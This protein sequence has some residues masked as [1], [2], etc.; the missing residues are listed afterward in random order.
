MGRTKTGRWRAI[1]LIMVNVLM[2]AHLIQWLIAGTTIAPI[3]PSEA[4]E[5]L[6]VGMINAGAIL[7]ALTFLSTLI[8]GRFFC[9]WLC[10]M[11]A[12]QDLC[13][14]M[15]N[16][17][18]IR[19]KPFRSRLLILFPFA[20]GMY[21]F[22]WPTFKRLALA[23]ILKSASIDWPAWL[24]P[25]EPISKYSTELI[26]DDFWATMPPWFIAVPFLFICGFAAVYFLGAKGFCTYGCPY[27]AFFKPMDKVAPLR[28]R[29]DD[30]CEQCGYCTSVCTSNV[31][32]SEEVRDFGMVV[33]AGCMKTLDCI[34]A[35]PNDALSLGFGKPALGAKPRSPETYIE[36]KAKRARR[37]DLSIGQ[38]VFASVL[39]L[40]F[41]F[42]TR[43]L[44]DAVPMLLAGGLAAIGVMIVMT[45]IK[46]FGEQNA[47][48][49][50]RQLKLQGKLKPAGFVMIL[51]AIVFVFASVWSGHAKA[52]RWRGDV[53]YA[54]SSLPT[55]VLMRTEFE[56]SPAQRKQAES[57][58]WAYQR[59]DSFNNGGYGWKLSA[60]HRLRLSY[61]LGVLGHHQQAYDQLVQ[62]IEDGSPTDQLV[63]QAGQLLIIAINANPPEQEP[64]GGFESYKRTKLLDLYARSLEMHPELHAIRAELARSAFSVGEHEKAQAYWETTEFDDDP[65]F[66]L[67]QAGYTSFTG[68]MGQTRVLYDRAIE[69]AMELDEPEA[70]LIDIARAAMQNRM[71]DLALE[72]AQ[73]AVDFEDATT[74]T[75]LAAGEIA[76][77]VGQSELGKERALHA[78]TMP[79]VD[80]PMVQIRAAN[81][82]ALPG[83]TDRTRE[84]L[85][86][87]A[88]RADDP[89]E[90]A[91]IARGMV[92]AGRSLG[93]Q[94]MLDQGLEFFKG[95]TRSYPDLY[96][97][98][99]DYALLLYQ[100]G[101]QQEAADELVRVAELD[102]NNA[103]FAKRAG[104]ILRV[105]GDEE[106]AAKWTEEAQKRALL[107]QE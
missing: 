105:V 43:G 52:M 67:A 28:V 92:F 79:G 13:A 72:L 47:R 86:D 65:A 103:L 35:C 101:H 74:L 62:V 42:A 4:M 50:S 104:E 39:F 84:L 64:E 40:W 89:F 2:V 60:E 88:E 6:E 29:V 69:L 55:S 14:Y 44:L 38:E 83:D 58:V 97:L 37:Y 1:V 19:P 24:R 73:R 76:N 68:E 57:A 23:P 70:L 33:D 90:V 12:L 36:A 51:V 48:L 107:E 26:V 34:S 87:A 82:L 100:L 54:G 15:M 75:W 5:T 93:D 78:L 95:V 81:V 18:G 59:G 66:F 80:R 53:H 20:L 98:G 8:L 102:S 96:V 11:V 9:G 45:T 41:F 25:V 31:R 49:Y 17:I 16:R 99:Y 85:K 63:I 3:E 30:S 46:L 22:V 61:F 91:Y 10:H 27:A 56:P 32:V 21:M 94:L 7:F 106:S 71:I 77:M